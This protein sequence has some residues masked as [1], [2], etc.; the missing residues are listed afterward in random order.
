METSL[1]A[2]GPV[3]TDEDLTARWIEILGVG[4]WPS[5]CLTRTLWTAFFDPHG[6]QSPVLVPLDEL[7]LRPQWPDVDSVMRVLQHIVAEQYEGAPSVALALERP[8]PPAATGNDRAWAAALQRAAD[9]HKVLLRRMH[10]A[11]RG[12]VL[13]LG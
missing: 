12:W 6:M 3:L 10:I 4:G 2:R 7:P 13:P 5:P 9:E 8:G 11:G 1:P